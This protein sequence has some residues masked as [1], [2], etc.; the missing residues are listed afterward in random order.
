VEE[1]SE[2]ML[3][4]CKRRKALA[5]CAAAVASLGARLP[6]RRASSTLGLASARARMDASDRRGGRRR[7]GRGAAPTTSRTRLR[8]PFGREIEEIVSVHQHVES[9]PMAGIRVED[10]ATFILIDRTRWCRALPCWGTP[11][12]R[13]RAIS[14]FSTF[15]QGSSRRFGLSSSR[16]CGIVF[17]M[18]KY[19]PRVSSHSAL[20]FFPRRR[21]PR[22]FVD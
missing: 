2:R 18:C 15:S 12:C 9:S 8:R 16:Q 5:W 6:G 7:S 11:A 20:L 1:S 4:H 14:S 21:L 22:L 10:V 3:P 19:D 17:S 13:S